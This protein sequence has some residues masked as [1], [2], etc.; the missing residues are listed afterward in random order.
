M[1]SVSLGALWFHDVSDLSDFVTVEVAELVERPNTESPIRRYANGVLRLIQ[2]AGLRRAYS[3]FCPLVAR[4]TADQLREWT[5]QVLMLRDPLGRKMFG[6][7]EEAMF[8][9]LPMIDTETVFEVELTFDE[10]THSEEV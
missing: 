4:A 1:A 10:V 9:E 7:F 3:V 2:V 6:R 8:R 5:G